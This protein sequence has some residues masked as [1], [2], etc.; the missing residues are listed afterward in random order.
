M[1]IVSEL[2]EEI[3]PFSPRWV[4]TKKYDRNNNLEKYKARLVVKG[5]NQ[6]EG[7]DYELTFSPTLPVESLRLTIA[8]ASLFNWDIQQLDVKGAYLNAKLHND[9][10]MKLQE[11]HENY[12]EGFL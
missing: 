10:Y 3:K 5:Y 7:V 11:R 8:L 9:I 6:I 4:F 2:P 1:T 12:N